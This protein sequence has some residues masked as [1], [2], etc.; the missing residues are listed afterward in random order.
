M[1]IETPRNCGTCRHYKHDQ[2]FC[3]RYPPAPVDNRHVRYPRTHWDDTC[4]EWAA[5]EDLVDA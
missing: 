4:G 5:R 2:R 1:S 3:R